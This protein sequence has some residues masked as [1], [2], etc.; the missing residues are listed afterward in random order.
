MKKKLFVKLVSLVLL[1]AV[2]ML[3]SCG[4]GNTE[5]TPEESG[6]E[7]EQDAPSFVLS[8]TVAEIN[9][10]MTKEID[11][12]LKVKN[13]LSGLKYTPSRPADDY[14]SD[15][16][17]QKLTDGMYMDLVYAPHIYAGWNGGTALDITFDTGIQ[18]TPLRISTLA[19][20]KTIPPAR[21]FPGT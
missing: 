16:A 10:Y 11:R 15:S 13:V 18:S 2:G 20:I 5:S 9:G 6:E 12:S 19:A 14:Y 4:G 17:C 7:T 3:P 21:R 8:E 1:V